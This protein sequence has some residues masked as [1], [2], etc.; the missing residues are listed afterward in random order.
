M[1]KLFS[2]LRASLCLAALATLGGCELYL[3]DG[4]DSDGGDRWT[5]CANDGYY[6][7]NG[8][9][10]EW[11]GA[12]CPDEPGYT[13][14]SDDDCAQGCYCSD[15]G[16]CEEAGFCNNDNQCPEGYSCD[17]AR[18]SCVPE[19]CESDADCDQGEYCNANTGSCESSCTC[20]TDAEAQAA[21]WAYCDEATSTCKPTPDGGSCQ[22]TATGGT[23]PS[24]AAGEVGLISEGQWTGECSAIGSCDLTPECEKLQHEGD[25]IGRSGTCTSVY[26]GI[27]CTNP[28]S[29]QTC[30]A[31]DSGCVCESFQFADC[32]TNTTGRAFTYEGANGQ[33]IDMFSTH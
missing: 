18:S 5:Y 10:C 29:G 31:G 4:G 24:C 26:Y 22:G 15:D 23:E 2:P 12:R 20:T 21:G 17:E 32:R 33:L 3:G 8:G 1:T 7:C 19:A 16:V 11:A 6:V 25:C 28:Q 14:A 27:N 13:C 9:D 30:A